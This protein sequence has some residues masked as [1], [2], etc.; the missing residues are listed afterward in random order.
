MLKKIVIVGGGVAALSAAEAARKADDE[1][2]IMM[3]SAEDVL[4]YNRTQLSDLFHENKSIDKLLLKP[5]SWFTDKNIKIQLGKKVKEIQPDQNLIALT[6]GSFI[7]YDSL[8]IAAGAYNFVPPFA[9]KTERVTSLRT[10]EDAKCLQ[11]QLRPHSQVLIVGGG[12]LGL[13][14]AYSLKLAGATIIVV[15]VANELIPKQADSKTSELIQTA[16]EQAEIQLHLGVSVTAINEENDSVKVTLSDNT[17]LSVDLVL[18]S[19]GI[20]SRVCLAKNAQLAVNRGILVNERMQTSKPNIYAC[21]DCAEYRGTV[22]GLWANAI[23]QGN[24]AGTNAAGKSVAYVPWIPR[25]MFNAFEV[26][27]FSIG[28]I[29]RSPQE[30]EEVVCIFQ[31]SEDTF[32]RLFLRDKKAIGGLLFNTNKNLSRISKMVE[33]NEVYLEENR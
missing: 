19:I 13:E 17:Q 11:R 28:E 27:F 10:L 31:D 16:L 18:F 4:P 20:R 22:A 21:G 25:T 5:L 9:E 12:L 26:N 33:N 8:V 6:D 14:A 23:K 2:E 29:I 7:D 30:N 32:G 1:A 24:V 15:E 3:V